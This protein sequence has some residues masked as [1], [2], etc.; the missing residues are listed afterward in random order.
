MMTETQYKTLKTKVLNIQDEIDSIQ[1]RM[2]EEASKLSDVYEELFK[3]WNA[4]KA[5]D[6]IKP[7]ED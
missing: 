6:K 4:F 7:D 2:H 1:M 3:L 5:C